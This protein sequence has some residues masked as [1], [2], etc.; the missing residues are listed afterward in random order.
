MS[1]RGS[2]CLTQYCCFTVVLNP[3]SVFG[4]VTKNK[5]Y[6]QAHIVPSQIIRLW[7]CRHRLSGSDCVGTDYQ[8]QTVSSQIIRLRLCRHKL[9]VWDCVNTDYQA[10]TVSSQIIRLRLCH[11]RMFWVFIIFKYFRLVNARL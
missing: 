8:A 5:T 10:E 9:S 4:F 2:L 3:G 7:L 1:F 6:Y 11:N